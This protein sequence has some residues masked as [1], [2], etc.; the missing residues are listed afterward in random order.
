M[1][2]HD[3]KTDPEVWAAVS[4][5]SKTFEIRLNDRGFA[6][7][8]MLQL[9]E[10]ES[11][12]EQMR[13][14]APLVYTGRAL[15]RKVTHILTGYGLMDGW[16]CLSLKSDMRQF[17]DDELEQEIEVR[18]L[19]C[20]RFVDLDADGGSDGEMR[21]LFDMLEVENWLF[22]SNPPKAVRKA[23]LESTGRIL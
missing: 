21:R 3:L 13:N 9:L 8:D 12:G 20:G 17:D 5:G 16:C 22:S 2:T 7:G 6:V 23:Y 19:E 4:D 14:G 18:G 15:I 1:T 10:T 11:T